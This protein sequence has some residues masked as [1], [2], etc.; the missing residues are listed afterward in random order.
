MPIV[1]F[2]PNYDLKINTKT[3][4]RKTISTQKSFILLLVKQYNFFLAS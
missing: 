3:I 1:R 4:F 2:A